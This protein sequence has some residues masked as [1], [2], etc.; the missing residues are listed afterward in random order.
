MGPLVHFTSKRLQQPN[1]QMSDTLLS[2]LADVKG[3]EITKGTE[4]SSSYEL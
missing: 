4:G 1:Q 3:T 2:P